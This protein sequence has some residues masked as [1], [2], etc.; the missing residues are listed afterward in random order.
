MVVAHPKIT[1]NGA[2]TYQKGGG[3]IPTIW[4]KESGYQFADVSRQVGLEKSLPINEKLS[5]SVEGK[6]THSHANVS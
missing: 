5:I 3:T 4:N 6:L 2:E 1:I